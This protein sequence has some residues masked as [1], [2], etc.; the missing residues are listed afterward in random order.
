MKRR[1]P[2][3]YV[4]RTRRTRRT[5]RN[6][7]MSP[8]FLFAFASYSISDITY[9]ESDERRR[10]SIS[11]LTMWSVAPS[12]PVGGWQI[13]IE[14]HCVILV[15]TVCSRRWYPR[16]VHAAARRE[17]GGGVAVSKRLTSSRL[18]D[19]SISNIWAS[20]AT[21]QLCRYTKDLQSK[22]IQIHLEGRG[23]A[24]GV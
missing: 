19:C 22:F 6:R 18:I 3:V 1:A 11:V 24:A 2:A 21:S 5:R 12:A 20:A 16:A 14:M 8:R 4:R 17:A 9:Y 23:E 10:E 13:Q 15:E 7:F